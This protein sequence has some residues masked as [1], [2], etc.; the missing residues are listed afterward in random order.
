MAIL[1]TYTK[2]IEIDFQTVHVEN[3]LFAGRSPEDPTTAPAARSYSVADAVKAGWGKGLWTCPDAAAL[4]SG[5]QD[6]AAW[7]TRGDFVISAAVRARP[8]VTVGNGGKGGDHPYLPRVRDSQLR[9]RGPLRQVQRRRMG[10][11][12]GRS[13]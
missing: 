8:A 12:E 9:R 6:A 13:R 3:T 2:P 1:P 10:P 4:F 7:K 11:R 5:K